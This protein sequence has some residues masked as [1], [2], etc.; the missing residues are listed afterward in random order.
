MKPTLLRA[1]LNPAFKRLQRPRRYPG[2][3]A[4]LFLRHGKSGVSS[5][6]EIHFGYCGLPADRSR[7][8]LG[9]F[10]DGQ[11]RPLAAHSRLPC[12][13]GGVWKIG[14]PSWEIP[15]RPDL[16]IQLPP[17]SSCWSIGVSHPL[18][19]SNTPSHAGF[20]RERAGAAHQSRLAS[21]HPRTQPRIAAAARV[22]QVLSRT[23]WSVTCPMFLAVSPAR[24]C[25][26]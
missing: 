4:R 17:F 16:K 14:M 11:R 7:V 26:S 3:L 13:R 23:Y 8:G 25:Q 5:G 18:H 9:H 20:H 6:D 1:K 19:H 21:S 24:L 15:L 12:L 22:L 2:V 10:A